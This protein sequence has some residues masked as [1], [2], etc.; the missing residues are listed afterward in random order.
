MTGRRWLDPH[1][2]WNDPTGRFL[3][4]CLRGR[5]DGRALDQAR[6]LHAAGQVD[7][8][9]LTARGP[10]RLLAP[11]LYDVLRDQPWP[12]Q[13]ALGELKAVYRAHAARNTLLL[14]ELE[15]VSALLRDAGVRALLLKGAALAAG[16]YGNAALRPMTDL[17]ILVGREGLATAIGQLEADGYVLETAFDAHPGMTLAFENHAVFRKTGPPKVMLELHWALFDSPRYQARLSND[18]F[19]ETAERIPLGRA[20]ALVLGPEAQLIYLC[21]HLVMHHRSEGLLWLQDV[22]E[23]LHACRSRLRWDALLAGAQETELVT[24]LQRVLSAAVEYL[25]APA[26]ADAL[27]AL[28]NLEPTAGE[29][30]AIRRLKHPGEPTA[31]RFWADLAGM[32]GWGMRLR[33]GLSSLFPSGEYMIRRYHIR[34]EALAPFYYPYRWADGLRRALPGWTKGKGK[35]AG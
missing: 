17:D 34:H 23:V 12:P 30:A 11:L 27:D 35:P 8:G 19:W 16:T 3:L 2:A 14:H 28:R 22:S 9:A 10:Q 26:P 21:A 31:R 4:W 1:E 20:E 7:W 15:T 18:W 32:S 6:A 5:F 29:M 13:G 25:D 33:Y 24:P